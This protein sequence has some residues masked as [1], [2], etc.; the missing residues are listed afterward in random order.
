MKACSEVDQ[1]IRRDGLISRREHPSLANTI[2]WLVRQG[3]LVPVLPGI[4]APPEV[5]RNVEILRRA[6]SLRHPDA[7]VLGAQLRE[8]PSGPTRR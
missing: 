1:L 2:A 5:A 4:Y 8:C 7:V 3:K 6:V